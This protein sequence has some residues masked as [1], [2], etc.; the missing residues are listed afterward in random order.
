[1]WMDISQELHNGIAN[2]PGDTPFKYQLDTTIDESGVNVGRVEASLHIG[3]HLDAPYHYDNDGLKIHELDINKLIDRAQIIEC[4][5]IDCITVS[6]IEGIEIEA[7][8]VLFKTRYTKQLD[9]FTESFSILSESLIDYLNQH[10]VSIVGVDTPSVDAYD[11][12]DLPVHHACNRANILIIENLELSKVR[13]GIYDFI[14]LPMK[15][16]GDA[17]PIRAVVKRV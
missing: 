16:I 5:D 11:D 13:A 7:P 6:D 17:S 12:H 14:G 8:I 10:H 15:V 2:W 1:M 4:L 3:T 9:A